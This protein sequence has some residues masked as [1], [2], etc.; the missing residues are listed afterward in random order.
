MRTLNTSLPSNQNSSRPHSDQPPE[1][2]LQA[3]KNAALSVTTLYKQTVSEQS[4]A[5]LAGYQDAIDDLLSFLDREHIG[6]RDGDGGKIRQW[7]TERCEKGGHG[8]TPGD[9]DDDR[10]E[11]EDSK[12]AISEGADRQ[13]SQ[14]IEGRNISP[15]VTDTASSTNVKIE[16]L[17]EEVAN[18]SVFTFTA[19]QSLPVADI[20]MGSADNALSRTQPASDVSTSMQSRTGNS[21]RNI[22]ALNR[23]GSSKHGN[24]ISS[25]RES[26]LTTGAKRK[27]QFSEF[28][29][30]SSLGNTR[31]GSGGKRGRFA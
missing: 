4:N 17:V 30:I 1:Q 16:S 19:G 3:F 20:D 21:S 14:D 7:A 6:L 15:T 28:F 27:F 23:H 29:D 13:N 8:T 24:R 5:R 26:N 18:P 31:E 22:R 25:V 11:I 12:N 9:S 10:G 2:L